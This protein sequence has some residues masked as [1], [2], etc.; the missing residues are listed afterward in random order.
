MEIYD[1]DKLVYDNLRF[2]DTLSFGGNL[3]GKH[4]SIT[5]HYNMAPNTKKI[6][7]K[8]AKLSK[9]EEGPDYD[10]MTIKTKALKPKL[11]HPKEIKHSEGQVR[12]LISDLEHYLEYAKA[13]IGEPSGKTMIKLSEEIRDTL[14][15][16][17]TTLKE[18]INHV[19]GSSIDGSVDSVDDIGNR[20]RDVKSKISGMTA[21]IEAINQELK[22]INLG[23]SKYSLASSV[24]MLSLACIAIG[25][26]LMSNPVKSKA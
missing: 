21:G 1:Q 6:I 20:L 23:F 22:K 4:F 11:R 7:L 3:K 8:D 10:I 24:G 5:S 17:V 2:K 19:E 18:I 15:A 9:R 14:A 25:F 12:H 16:G 13:I 26:Y